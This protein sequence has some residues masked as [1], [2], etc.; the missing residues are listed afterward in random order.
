[1][2]DP[3]QFALVGER[4]PR[5]QFINRN[6]RHFGHFDVLIAQFATGELQQ[7]VVHGLVHPPSLGDEPVVD[8]AQRREHMPMYAGL[9]GHLPDRGL[10]GGLA[11]LDVSLRQRPDHPPPPVHSADQRRRLLFTRP[12]DAVDDKSTRGDFVHGA[13][14]GALAAPRRAG[15]TGGVNGRNVGGAAGIA[16]LR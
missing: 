4:Q 5:W 12:V 10:L 14:P 9:L 1:M 13:Q 11:L 2:G 6:P 7:V 16:D 8:A 15:R 3:G